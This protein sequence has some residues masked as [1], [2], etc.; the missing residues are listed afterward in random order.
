MVM[1]ICTPGLGRTTLRRDGL[2]VA[3]EA[4]YTLMG[5]WDAI[6]SAWDNWGWAGVVGAIL[7]LFA[8]LAWLSPLLAGCKELAGG[9]R[10]CGDWGN[11]FVLVITFLFALAGAA[12]L[13]SFYK[14]IS[15]RNK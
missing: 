6:R 13:G 12:L 4:S 11:V 15:E 14:W 5:I 2:L 1:S 9:G 8:G 3:E 10:D 7:G